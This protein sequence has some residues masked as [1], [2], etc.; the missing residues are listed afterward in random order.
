MPW[1]RPH[2]RKKKRVEEIWAV[3]SAAVYFE[4]C[5]CKGR[6]SLASLRYREPMTAREMAVALRKRLP[7]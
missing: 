4:K 7:I 1:K 5:D 3:A 6:V 2:R